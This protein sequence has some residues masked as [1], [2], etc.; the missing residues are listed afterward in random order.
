MTDCGGIVASFEGFVSL[1]FLSAL[2]LRDCRRERVICTFSFADVAFSDAIAY[3]KVTKTTL[4]LAERVQKP[5]RDYQTQP[6]HRS[7]AL[8][9]PRPR[10][11]SYIK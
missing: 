8:P 11:L 9:V 2:N 3:V 10:A 4:L 1:D 5:P 6:G 7:L